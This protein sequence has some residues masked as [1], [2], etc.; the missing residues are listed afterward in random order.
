MSLS[1]AARLRYTLVAGSTAVVIGAGF[2]SAGILQRP[3]ADPVPQSADVP[4]A[5]AAAPSGD[6][7]LPAAGDPLPS[8][9]PSPASSRTTSPTPRATVSKKAAT[10]PAT[11]RSTTKAKKTTEAVPDS[12]VPATADTILDLVLAHI[13][14]AR[15]DEGL[16]ALTLDTKLSKASAIHNQLMIDGCGLSH[17]CPG[18]G[19]IGTRFSAQ[20]V[21]WSSAGEN[22]GYGSS[23]SS[24]ADKVKAANGLTDSMLAEVAPN[25]G[26]RKNLL[27]KS[28]TKIGLSVVRDG[29]GITWMVQDFVG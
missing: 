29:K 25:D 26:H 11:T 24:A 7:G 27:S 17:Q 10:T 12:T 1:A 16:A 20:G 22:I 2:I 13:N 19:G 18:E 28:F 5:A 6:A 4:L 14:Q 21:S 15:A 3:S 9:T 23:G 8:S